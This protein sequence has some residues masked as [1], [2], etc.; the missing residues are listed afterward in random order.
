M[1]RPY[2]PCVCEHYS[3]LNPPRFGL[4]TFKSGINRSSVRLVLPKN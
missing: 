2:G 3:L 4:W 1:A